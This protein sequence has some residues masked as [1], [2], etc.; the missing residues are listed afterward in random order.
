MPY[1]DYSHTTVAIKMFK[2][3]S[4]IMQVPVSPDPNPSLSSSPDTTGETQ[5]LLSQLSTTSSSS[6]S[7]HYAEPRKELD[8][9]SAR[10]DLGLARISLFVDV[11]V[12]ALFLLVPT[13]VAFTVGSMLG[14]LAT[15]FSP[16]MQSVALGLYKRRGG[17]ENGKLFGALSVVQALW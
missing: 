10:F 2:P 12:Y 9:G 4:V 13:A 3:N 16:A 17:T 5:P 15:G 14:S 8:L 7:T 11:L 1:S 6:P